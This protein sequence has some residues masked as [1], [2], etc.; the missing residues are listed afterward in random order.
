MVGLFL[1]FRACQ[2]CAG[3]YCFDSLWC[4]FSQGGGRV[5]P[6]RARY[7][8]LLRQRNVPKRKAIHSLRPLRGKPASVRLRGAPW[9]SLCAARAAR[10]TTAS[11]L[12]RHARTDAHAHPATAPPQA[13]PDGIGEGTSKQPFGPSLRSAPHARAQAPRAAHSEPSAAMARV[14]VG[15]YTLLGAPAARRGWRIRARD[16]L[17]AAGAS[18]SE[19]PPAPSTA[20]CPERSV[21]TQTAGS[22]FFW[23]LFFGGAKNKYL[24]RRGDSRPPPSAKAQRKLSKQ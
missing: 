3:S 7:F 18:S 17:S 22:P 11:Q 13:Q 1:G 5:S 16:C 6:R 2:H 15:C 4:A 19:T 8:S 23:V 12:T 21:G 14:A 10:T 20:G 9:N 24:A